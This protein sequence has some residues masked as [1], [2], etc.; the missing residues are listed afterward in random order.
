VGFALYAGLVDSDEHR[1]IRPVAERRRDRGTIRREAIAYVLEVAASRLA[2][3]LDE[4]V[5]GGLIA[6]ASD[7]VSAP[8]WN[9]AQ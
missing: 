3:A 6:F 9:S 2:Q 8:I 7:D 1:A 4:H 5:G